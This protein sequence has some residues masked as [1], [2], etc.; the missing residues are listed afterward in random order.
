VTS[1]YTQAF[2]KRI[3]NRISIGVSVLILAI[4]AFI[5]S[6]LLREI[7]VG[8]VVAEVQAKPFHT[9]LTAACFVAI[10]YAVLTCYDLFALRTIGRETVPYRVAAFAGFA[11]YTIGHNLGATV[12]TAGAI[13]LRIYSAWGLTLI[14]VG[15]IA[16]VTGLTF[17]LGNG[18]VL[19]A[20][21]VF[22]PTAASAID[23]LPIWV[24]RVIGIASLALISAYI[25]WLL[26]RPRILGPFKAQ[27]VLPNVRLTLVQIA[28]G[29]LDLSAA[30]TVM[31]MLLPAQP[32]INFLPFVVIF[33]TASLLGFL[34]HAPGSLG[35]VEAAMLIGLPQ[36]QK[37]K[38]LASLLIFRALYFM[39]PLS[40]AAVLLGAREISLL[41][42]ATDRREQPERPSGWR[43]PIRF[44]RAE[45]AGRRMPPVVQWGVGYRPGQSFAHG[46]KEIGGLSML[47]LQ[48]DFAKRR[49]A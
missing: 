22:V 13:R 23:H 8:R 5:L 26:P 17:W 24:N 16:F 41:A 49:G 28:I 21:M 2:R 10:S 19:G 9:L 3:R 12:L 34:S 38:L 15:K 1:V 30:A 39:L 37:D 44:P 45:G 25:C 40:I 42:K 4:A 33:A 29:V 46:F 47:E 31:Y 14:D 18:F 6:R 43:W 20:G 11:A 32:D 7:E 35:V 27:I 36:F 48:F